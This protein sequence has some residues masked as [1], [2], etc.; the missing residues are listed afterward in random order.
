[1]KRSDWQ[2]EK[3]QTNEMETSHP[4]GNH[5][6]DFY[7]CRLTLPGSRIGPCKDSWMW[8]VAEWLRAGMG[9]LQPQTS[10]PS[11]SQQAISLL[12]SLNIAK[13]MKVW[14]CEEKNSFDIE[15]ML[16]YL[17]VIVLLSFQGIFKV[18]SFHLSQMLAEM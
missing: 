7:H 17:Y 3:K 5:W 16:V 14:S 13:R 8:R 2:G 18:S 11:L 10:S 12:M 4:L 1:M 9:S 15:T 6:S